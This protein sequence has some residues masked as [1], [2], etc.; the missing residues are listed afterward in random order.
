MKGDK[1]IHISGGSKF[2]GLRIA[3]SVSCLTVNRAGPSCGSEGRA[4]SAANISD[5]S[6]P[7][8]VMRS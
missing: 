6:Q 2:C 3:V 7:V 8:L 1:L 4:V 5:V